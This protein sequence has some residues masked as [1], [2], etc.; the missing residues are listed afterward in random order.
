[1]EEF[2]DHIQAF[3]RSNY[4]CITNFDTAMQKG[5]FD[6]NISSVDRHC[7]YCIDFKTHN[8]VERIHTQIATLSIIGTVDFGLN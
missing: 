3:E 8:I 6:Y 5:P 2:T 4:H 7:S 1:M